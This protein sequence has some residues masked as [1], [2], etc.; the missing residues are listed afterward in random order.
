MPV[1]HQFFD[2]DFCATI[3]PFAGV[4]HV[5]RVGRWVRHI[6]LEAH[7]HGY[8]FTEGNGFALRQGG[9]RGKGPPGGFGDLDPYDLSFILSVEA[10]AAFQDLTLSGR[11]DQLV[12]Q[13]RYAWPNVFRT[14]H[15][16]PAVEYVQANRHRT[17]LMARMA[18]VFEEVDVYVT[19]TFAG[20]SLLVTNLTGH[21]Q[22]VVPHGFLAG[23]SPR[24]VGFVGRL[25]DEATVLAVAGAYQQATE[26]HKK[27]P[28]G[29]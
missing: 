11:D 27:T 15:M 26:W 1:V 6:D 10:A 24:S 19:P 4:I 25:Y 17:E 28:P 23:N 22:A 18:G 14:A 8:G 3:A 9:K 2:T 16:I 5:G 12:R 13:E 7:R 20:S 21:P 29:F